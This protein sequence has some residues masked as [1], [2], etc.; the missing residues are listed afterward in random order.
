MK[1]CKIVLLAAVILLAAGMTES[2]ARAA[3]GEFG[4]TEADLQ[5]RVVEALVRGYVPVYPDRAKFKAASPAARAA[6]V[7]SALTVIKGYTET[8]AFLAKYAEQRAAEKPSV[9]PPAAS[10]D[11]QYAE[12]L[13]KAEKELVRMR[14][15]I[16]KMLPEMQKQMESVLKAVEE[17]HAQQANDPQMAAMMKHGLAMQAE[18]AQQSYQEKLRQYAERYPEDPRTLIVKRLREFLE[19]SKDILYNAEL[20]PAGEGRMKFADPELEAKSS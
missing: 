20:T 14:E 10:P 6:F 3:L 16:A 11:E 18:H 1:Q 17:A 5:S 7:Q 9:S 19:L 2:R 8:E 13:A 15:D 12:Y 4:I